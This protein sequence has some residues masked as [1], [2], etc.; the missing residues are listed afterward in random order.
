MA[1]VDAPRGFRPYQAGGKQLRTRRY[2]KTADTAVY[3]GDLL[4][5]VAAGTVEPAEAGE[6]DTIVGVA[7]RYSAA[8]ESYVDVYD[9]PDMTFIAQGDTADAVAATHYG[10]NVDILAGTPDSDLGRSGMELDISTA[11]ET[12]TLPIKILGLAPINTN[13]VANAL[14]VNAVVI[15]KLNHTEQAAGAGPDATA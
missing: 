14:G 12:A 7:A 9:D 3:E 2:A 10:Q 1:N 5:R 15:C 4:Q 11:A 13:G 8:S 6:T